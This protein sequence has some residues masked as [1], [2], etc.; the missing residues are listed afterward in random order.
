[1]L[2]HIPQIPWGNSFEEI[3]MLKRERGKKRSH[4]RR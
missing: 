1:M 3:N 2:L 4:K